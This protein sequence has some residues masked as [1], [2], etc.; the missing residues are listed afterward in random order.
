MLENWIVNCANFYSTGT[1]A[2]LS[3]AMPDVDA[4]IDKVYTTNDNVQRE[5]LVVQIIQTNSS[6]V[7]ICATK[8]L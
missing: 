8:W 6:L 7:L 2:L 4:L 3:K 1:Y 5:K